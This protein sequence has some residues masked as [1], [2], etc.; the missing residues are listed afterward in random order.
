METLIQTEKSSLIT[1]DLEPEMQALLQQ[2]V[3]E[4]DTELD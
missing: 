1:Y 4:V 2:S 3:Q